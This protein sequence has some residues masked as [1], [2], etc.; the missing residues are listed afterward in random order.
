V[1]DAS[2]KSAERAMTVLEVLAGSVRPLPTMIIASRCEIPKTSAYR[3]L[4]AMRERG[5]VTYYD[6]EHAWGLGSTAFEI[7]SSY[8]RQGALQ[9]LGRPVLAALAQDT[10]AVAHLAILHGTEVLYVD[11]QGPPRGDP[12]ATSTK[13]G[14]RLQAHL[15]AAGRAIL[16]QFAEHQL[17]ALYGDRP[18]AQRSGTG[19]ATVDELARELR[20]HSE[21]GVAFAGALA[22]INTRE[23]AAAVFSREGSA[24]AALEVTFPLGE[25]DDCVR[26]QSIVRAAARFSATL[27]ASTP[28][29]IGG[30]GTS[31]PN[32]RG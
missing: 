30:G 27:G 17:R 9:R 15:T 18:L 6:A 13:L 20:S 11:G 16:A 2:V 21:T 14:A 5:F 22:G 8:L 3:L 29:D 26:T 32:R 28:S 25:G 10:D 7:G 1:A 24:V 19:T 4:N 23:V 12:A 31:S